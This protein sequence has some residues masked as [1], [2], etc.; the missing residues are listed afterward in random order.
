MADP[1]K[2]PVR[3][4]LPHMSETTPGLRDDGAKRDMAR[5]P[6]PT[7]TPA[8]LPR[9]PPP[10]ISLPTNVVASPILHPLPKPAGVSVQPGPPTQPAVTSLQP[11]PVIAATPRAIDAFDSIPRSFCWGLLGISV[12][13]FLI[14]IWNYALS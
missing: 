1:E 4:A 3:G 12:L 9:R 13:I 10:M 11:A 2:E 14:Q 8:V 6:L 5:I 7:R